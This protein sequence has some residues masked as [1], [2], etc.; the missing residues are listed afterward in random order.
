VHLIFLFLIVLLP[1]ST[2]LFGRTG[3]TQAVVTIY[4]THLV[5]IGLMNLLLWIDVHRRVAAHGG[6]AG[7]SLVL[8]LFVAALAIGEVRPA[9]AEYLWFTAFAEPLLTPHLVALDLAAKRRG[10]VREI[11]ALRMKTSLAVQHRR[12][13]FAP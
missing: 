1:I 9:I 2:S 6:V 3:S 8:A 4:G 13:G 11:G 10:V 7:S 12:C 5:L